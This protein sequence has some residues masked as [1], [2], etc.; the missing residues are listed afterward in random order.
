MNLYNLLRLPPVLKIYRRHECVADYPLVAADKR[1]EKVFP[2]GVPV[3][4]SNPN[5]R[6]IGS[7]EEEKRL[8]AIGPTVIKYLDWFKSAPAKVHCQQHRFIRELYASS[9]RMTGTLFAQALEQ[10]ML[11]D[12]ADIDAIE[13][14]AHIILRTQG[15]IEHPITAPVDNSYLTRKSYEEGRFSEEPQLSMYATLFERP[16]QDNDY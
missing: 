13:R 5:N 2:D 7:T 15:L 14:I 10:A 16:K 6:K 3:I 9:Q 12:I 8:R 4:H 11:H 1:G